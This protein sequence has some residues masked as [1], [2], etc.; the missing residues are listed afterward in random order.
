MSFPLSFS[1]CV[2]VS[3]PF[4]VYVCL[5]LSMSVSACFC[6]FLFLSLDQGCDTY[7]I[8]ANLLDTLGGLDPEVRLMLGGHAGMHFDMLFLSGGSGLVFSRFDS[9][10]SYV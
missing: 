5:C 6:V 4:S 1:F 3:V 9:A 2:F 7:L 8:P 10:H